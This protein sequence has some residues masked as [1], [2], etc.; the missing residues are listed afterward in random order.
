MS[1]NNNKSNN[2]IE[3]IIE[4]LKTLNLEETS[5]LVERFKSVFNIK[6]SNL[7]FDAEEKTDDKQVVKVDKVSVYIT[8]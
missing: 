2:K 8:G 5:E 7:N 1:E 4:N 6:G 3:E